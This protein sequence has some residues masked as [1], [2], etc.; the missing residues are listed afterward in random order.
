MY[1]RFL[2]LGVVFMS[3]WIIKN[4]PQELQ[5]IAN[6]IDSI[7]NGGNNDKKISGEETQKFENSVWNA[8]ENGK[9][10]ADVAKT[11]CD[12]KRVD[13]I[14]EKRNPS[15]LTR[16]KQTYKDIETDVKGYCLAAQEGF[17]TGGPKGALLAMEKYQ[18]LNYERYVGHNSRENF[19]RDS[20]NNI[21]NNCP[22]YFAK[23]DN[24]GYINVSWY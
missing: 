22:R 15:L 19:A 3:E 18:G 23:D 10:T 7:E 6:S 21:E 20:W 9:I 16:I 2:F 8:Y 24:T 17:K 4:L 12:A 1:V 5:N 11:V 13:E 14:E